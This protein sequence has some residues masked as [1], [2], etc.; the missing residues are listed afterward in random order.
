MI[1]TPELQHCSVDNYKNTTAVKFTS[2]PN[3]QCGIVSPQPV[4]MSIFTLLFFCDR[5]F[6]ALLIVGIHFK[7]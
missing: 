6:L 3:A 5:L 2:I 7:S 1:V 4:I